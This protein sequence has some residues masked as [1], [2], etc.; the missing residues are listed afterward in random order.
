MIKRIICLLLPCVLMAFAACGPTQQ[1]NAPEGKSIE[2]TTEGK[3]E[4]EIP[5]EDFTTD[6]IA[7]STAESESAISETSTAAATTN[8]KVNAPVGGSAAQVVAFYNQYANTVKSAEK[9]TIKKH[10]KRDMV[11]DIPAVMKAL[12]P[13]DANPSGGY[14]DE[15]ITETFIKGMGVKNTALKLNDFLPVNGKTYVSQLK[16]SNVK[17]AACAKQGNGWVVTIRLKDEPLD[18]SAMEMGSDISESDR[19]KAMDDMMSKSGYGSCMEISFGG[20]GLGGGNNEN[21]QPPSSIDSGSMKMEGTYQN[22]S[23]TAVFNQDGQ[24]ISLTHSYESLMNMTMM[25]MKM[26][27]NSTLK[28]EYQFTW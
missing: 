15:T 7:E 16:V 28:Q 14:T 17:N 12:M 25:G 5:N 21:R 10:D 27:M 1:A 18:T 6:G 24:L 4:S 20:G 2:E 11:M 13:S 3:S 23:I 22:G 19:Q 8:A 26:S 9:V